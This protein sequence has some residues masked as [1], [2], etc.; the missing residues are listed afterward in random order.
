[1][2]ESE[3][4]TKHPPVE[5]RNA[6]GN[7]VLPLLGRAEVGHLF[8]RRVP[9][10]DWTRAGAA[11]SQSGRRRPLLVRLRFLPLHIP[12]GVLQAACWKGLIHPSVRPLLVATPPVTTLPPLN[13]EPF[14]M[15]RGILL[16]KRARG[17]HDDFVCR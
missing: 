9:A 4:A 3:L 14:H 8:R 13:P 15:P 1:M 17:V 5:G 12:R 16:W 11:A 10:D 6:G 2:S 7:Q